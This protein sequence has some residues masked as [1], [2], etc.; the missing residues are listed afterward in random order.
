M[1]DEPRD[2]DHPQPVRDADH[3]VEVLRR[4]EGSG[5]IWRVLSRA[6]DRLEIVLLTCTGDEE[7][8]RLT[9]SDPDLL[10]FVGDR[11]GSDV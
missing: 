9:S 6:P 4:W 11:A 10:A 2:A 3:P 7:M 5:A 8:G 1:T